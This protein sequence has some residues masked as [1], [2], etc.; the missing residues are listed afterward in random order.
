LD[1]DLNRT[2]HAPNVTALPRQELYH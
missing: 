1:I 2:F